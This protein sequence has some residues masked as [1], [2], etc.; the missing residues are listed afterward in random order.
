MTQTQDLAKHCDGSSSS[1]IGGVAPRYSY[2]VKKHCCLHNAIVSLL[3]DREIRF[4][5]IP[6]KLMLCAMQLSA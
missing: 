2:V 6:R 4:L 1:Q 3:P 5:C